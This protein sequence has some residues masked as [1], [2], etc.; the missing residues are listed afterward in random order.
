LK[1]PSK[2][3]FGALI[4]MHRYRPDTV[5]TVLHYLRDFRDKLTHHADHQQMLADSSSASKSEKTQ[6]IKDV[7]AIKKQLKELEDYEKPLFEVAARKIE[8]DLDDG[9][10]H[11]YL[12]FG[13]VLRKIP[14]LDAKED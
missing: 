8:I 9:V 14:G 4:Y 11:N 3:T 5:G 1:T 6:A 2:G 7:A 12:L 10:K 13:S